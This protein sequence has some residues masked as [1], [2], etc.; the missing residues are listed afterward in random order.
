MGAVSILYT[1]RLLLRRTSL[2]LVVRM[3]LLVHLKEYE[4]YC[5][6]ERPINDADES[7]QFYASQDG[8]EDK[9]RMDAHGISDDLWFNKVIDH[10]N[11]KQ[12]K[13]KEEN[14]LDGARRDKDINCRRKENAKWSKER[15][16]GEKRHNRPPEDRRRKTEDKKS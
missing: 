16:Q 15:N 10:G 8:E 6:D 5:G 3:M 13:K 14:G 9:E 11:K 12:V 2:C 7:E 1:L 4:E